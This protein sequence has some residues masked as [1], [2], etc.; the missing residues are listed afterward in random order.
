MDFVFSL[1]PTFVARGFS[2]NIDQ[3]KDNRNL[4]IRLKTLFLNSRFS[5]VAVKCSK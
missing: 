2:G 5:N 1:E 4:L 3:M